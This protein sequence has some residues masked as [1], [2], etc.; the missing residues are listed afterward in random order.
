MNM[1]HVN[2]LV[3]QK[4]RDVVTRPRMDRQLER[5][6]CG[7]PIDPESIHFVPT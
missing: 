2:R 5:H 1:D 6:P 3:S 4:L 7:D